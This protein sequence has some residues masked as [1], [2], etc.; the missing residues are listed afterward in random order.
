VEELPHA[1]EPFRQPPSGSGDAAPGVDNSAV[2]GATAQ[3]SL[4]DAAAEELLV[5]LTTALRA[6]MPGSPLGP[7]L[8]S[9][10]API[11]ADPFEYFG[12]QDAPAGID[13]TVQRTQ[14]LPRE[15][16]SAADTGSASIVDRRVALMTQDMAAFGGVGLEASLRFNG[17]ADGLRLDYF[18]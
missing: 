13:A 4:G 16:L 14:D 1:L 11:G 12:S 15:S 17:P 5:R 7:G 10:E 8:H 9:L 3:L 2:T 18:A 6:G